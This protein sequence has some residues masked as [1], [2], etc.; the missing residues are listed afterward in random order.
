MTNIK[1]IIFIIIIT[2]ISNEAFSHGGGLN[3][4]GCHNERKTGGYHCHRGNSST[5]KPSISSPIITNPSTRKSTSCTIT[6]GNEY[7]EFTPDK[8]SDV[9]INFQDSDKSVN[10]KCS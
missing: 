5:N 6:I 2:F 7:Y 4:Q 1:Q 8:T 3:A 10:I 9:N